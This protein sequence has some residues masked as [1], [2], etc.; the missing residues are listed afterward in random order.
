MVIKKNLE[1]KMKN[2]SP[3]MHV[4]HC[5]DT[6]GPMIEDL[7]DTFNRL[8]HIF[9]LNLNRGFS[10]HISFFKYSAHIFICNRFI[11]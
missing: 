4:V 7:N 8:N 11:Y 2:N 5:I 10:V 9:G 3:L 6:E 1:I